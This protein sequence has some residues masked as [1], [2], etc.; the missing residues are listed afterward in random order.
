L[1]RIS[2]LSLLPEKILRE[3]Q[4]PVNEPEKL[5][6]KKV[7]HPHD[8]TAVMMALNFLEKPPSE[9]I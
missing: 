7:K 2:E 5:R 6:A 9:Q 3:Y 1:S 4:L 8:E